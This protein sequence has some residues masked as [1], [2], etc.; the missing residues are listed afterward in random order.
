MLTKNDPTS[1]VVENWL[2]DF[3]QALPAPND[4]DLRALFRPD[5]H[6]RDVLA[7]TWTIQTLGGRDA[8]VSALK[9]WAAGARHR[10]RRRLA[11]GPIEARNWLLHVPEHLDRAPEILADTPRGIL[12]AVASAHAN[13]AARAWPQCR[14]TGGPKP[15]RCD[16]RAGRGAKTLAPDKTMAR[17]PRLSGPRMSTTKPSPWQTAR[18]SATP[19]QPPVTTSITPAGGPAGDARRRPY[20]AIAR[21]I[22]RG[23]F[24]PR[25]YVPRHAQRQVNGGPSHHPCR[26][27][28][29]SVRCAEGEW[30]C[31]GLRDAPRIPR[32]CDA[33]RNLALLGHCG[34][35]E[36]CLSSQLPHAFN[37][38][39]FP[40]ATDGSS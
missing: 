15:T 20:L 13:P 32:H 3:E 23:P 39:L 38:L 21:A 34:T 33:P 28:P 18:P 25:W 24:S 37:V 1:A 16:S 2:A 30:Q 27:A 40:V 22:L 9:Q 5:C 4:A 8:V 10:R 29:Q 19:A 36:S 12:I 26:D 6:W 7:L 14:P 35:W 17:R 31:R 11:E